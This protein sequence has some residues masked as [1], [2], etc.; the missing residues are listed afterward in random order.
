MKGPRGSKELGGKQRYAEPLKEER[1]PSLRIG[2]SLFYNFSLLVKAFC[3]VCFYFG[4][5]FLKFSSVCVLIEKLVR[6]VE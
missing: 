4:G 3:F 5:D 6:G 1:H 2:I